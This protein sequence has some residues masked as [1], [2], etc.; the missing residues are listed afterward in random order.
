MIA[1][2]L[3]TALLLAIVISGAFTFWLSKKFGS[4]NR[5]QT[6]QYLTTAQNME[7]G[8]IIR[9]ASFVLVDWAGSAALEG[10]FT[11][12]EEVLGRTL[13]YPLA[14]G[15]PILERQLYTGV[16]AG[17]AIKIPDRMRAISLKSDQVVGVAGFLL[18]GTHIDVLVTYHTTTSPEPV[19]STVLQDAQILAAGQKMQPDPEGRA[20][21]VD[22]VTILVNPQD[23]EKV[24]LASAQGSVH[25]VLRNGTDH[26]Q[27][28]EGP[29]HLSE[30]GGERVV[31]KPVKVARPAYVVPHSIKAPMPTRY[32]VQVTRGDKQ[33]VETF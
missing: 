4:H 5:A 18:P 15:E 28:S 14:K 12:P 11:K 22:V 21:P 31:V 9:P 25:F 8:E 29:V 20:V 26:E 33:T 16:G 30:L 3:V 1:R 6:R 2:R 19:T 17:M 23:A 10:A 24:V 7:A 32:A 27:R 13:L